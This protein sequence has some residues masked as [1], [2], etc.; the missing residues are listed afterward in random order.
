MKLKLQEMVRE[1]H[2]LN[3]HEF[4]QAPGVDDGQRSLACCSSWGHKESDT[5]SWLTTIT[6]PRLY[7]VGP[8]VR[9]CLRFSYPFWRIFSCYPMYR[10]LSSS[11]W[12][13]PERVDMCGSQKKKKKKTSRHKEWIP[14]WPLWDA[15]WQ[16][17]P[18]LCLGRETI[19]KLWTKC[20]FLP[21]CEHILSVS[22]LI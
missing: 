14:A 19:H 5:T 17:V 15:Q 2:Q 10:S 20:H 1:H 7:G 8:G 13:S 11:F 3:G 6:T 16:L 21:G 22:Y 9:L 18:R 4:E 12:S